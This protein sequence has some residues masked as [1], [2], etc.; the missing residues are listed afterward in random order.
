L[1]IF[2][3]SLD[4]SLP[5][6]NLSLQHSLLLIDHIHIHSFLQLLLLLFLVDILVNI[7]QVKQ[8]LFKI[9]GPAVNFL[10]LN[11]IFECILYFFV[12]RT[13][14]LLI[15]I[16]INYNWVC[17]PFIMQAV[18]P[19]ANVVHVVRKFLSC[20][21]LRFLQ[22]LNACSV[23]LKTVYKLIEN[24]WLIVQS[25]RFDAVETVYAS[26]RCTISF[27]VTNLFE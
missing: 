18:F 27:T 26:D 2:P 10:A 21:S 15:P 9:F 7:L 22:T 16:F 6:F 23:G 17:H 5:C 4:A 19:H 1:V 11:L 8:S 24:W 14:H 20:G 25:I 3:V 13:A 12:A